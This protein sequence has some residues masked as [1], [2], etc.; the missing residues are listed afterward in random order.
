MLPS[1]GTPTARRPLLRFDLASIS[2]DDRPNAYKNPQL[3]LKP[4][5][6]LPPRT[7]FTGLRP[8]QP[9]WHHYLM[10]HVKD[11]A[12]EL[13]KLD[14]ESFQMS[15]TAADSVRQHTITCLASSYSL[16]LRYP[17]DPDNGF[18][19][20]SV[21]LQ[22]PSDLEAILSQL[23]TLSVSV[24][25]EQASRGGTLVPMPPPFGARVP[26]SQPVMSA[27][28]PP[29]NPRQ[30]NS[31]TPPMLSRPSS[32][33][34]HVSHPE[35]HPHGTPLQRPPSQPQGQ[36]A[37]LLLGHRPWSPA[38][39]PSRPATTIGVPGILGE[40]IYKFSKVGSASS[41]RSRV[42][43][44]STII[45]PQ[46]PKLYTVSR[47]FDKTLSRADI[48]H[49]SKAR[50]LGRELPPRVKSGEPPQPIYELPNLPSGGTAGQHWLGQGDSATKPLAR[51]SSVLDAV[52]VNIHRQPRLRR[53]RTFHDAP[54]PGHGLVAD[55]EEYS[56]LLPSVAEEQQ[57]LAFSQ[58][59]LVS[60]AVGYA[61]NV[62]S[63]S[64]SPTLLEVPTR[65]YPPD[66]DWL[67]QVSQIQQEGLCEASRVWDDLMRRADG[68]V[69]SA[70]SSQD[71][72]SVLAKFEAEF[73]RCWEVSVA[74]TAHKMRQVRLRGFAS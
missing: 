73:A 68:E 11:K 50:Y 5:L 6:D 62:Y 59:E 42:G 41:G 54:D 28:R 48:L 21:T 7:P 32:T 2:I 27:Y 18:S 65:Q 36:P 1:Q 66:D 33:G 43:R 17:K 34:L 49:S 30:L 67:I 57:R 31:S 63:F 72:L 39:V 16:L 20:L 64:S 12:E 56:S 53:L 60:R 46:P 13:V 47:H 51:T 52:P 37:E 55:S 26:E 58:P 22:K 38:F 14:L 29:S 19:T 25:Y 44:T 45:E 15:P 74:S 69:A 40:G 10:V 4:Q 71:A 24:E 23:G 8:R 35:V 70:D 61:N 3:V 9:L